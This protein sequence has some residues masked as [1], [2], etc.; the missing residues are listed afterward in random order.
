MGVCGRDA[1][2]PG[3]AA[4]CKRYVY[5]ALLLP[6]YNSASV[7]RL[8]PAYRTYRYDPG[9]SPR[10]RHGRTNVSIPKLARA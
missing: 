3:G 4:T 7:A 2:R 8:I 1:R 9:A 10:A 5:V 6:P